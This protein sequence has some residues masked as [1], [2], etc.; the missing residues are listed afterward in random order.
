MLSTSSEIYWK[1]VLK[2]KEWASV[3]L[4]L[5]SDPQSTYQRALLQMRQKP[6]INIQQI[7]F[8]A[9]FPADSC[10]KGTMKVNES[11]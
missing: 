7:L 9:D 11:R 2:K 10:E 5:N 3:F 1:S 4:I 8:I 6:F